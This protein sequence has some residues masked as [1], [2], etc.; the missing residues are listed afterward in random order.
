MEN[1]FDIH[2]PEKCRLQ[3]PDIHTSFTY[4]E[5]N[6]GEEHDVENLPFNFVL[7]VLNG[8]ISV[9]CNEFVGRKFKSGEMIFLRRSSVVKV[10]AKAKTGMV[11][12]YF[13]EL[14]STCDRYMFRTFLPDVEKTTYNFSPVPIPEPVKAFLKQLTYFQ[15]LR[16]NCMHF[17]EVKHRELFLLI[18]WFSSRDE[19]IALFAPLI[20]VSQ[21]FRAK[22]LDNYSLMKEGRVS[23]LAT[24]VGMGRKNFDK[25]F[26]EEFAVSP[27]RW[28][29]METAKRVQLYLMEPGITI[30]DA[31][32]KF[33]FNSASHF[34]RFVRKNFNKRPG[35]IIKEA[36]EMTGEIIKEE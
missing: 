33:H 28:I 17:N 36:K 34:N 20:G 21:S 31:I 32:E 15:S 26:R 11:V 6:V 7:F 18:R 29:Q 23:E 35:E 25:R 30:A 5:L 8:E 13:D 24:L 27:A 22:V 10:K 3:E 16:L 9:C 14:I 19:I 2:K 4:Y 12:F 1:I